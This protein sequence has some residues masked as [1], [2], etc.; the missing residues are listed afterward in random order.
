MRW[1]LHPWFRISVV[2]NL[3]ALC[4]TTV[5]EVS[6]RDRVYHALGGAQR[7]FRARKRVLSPSNQ[8]TVVDF[9]ASAQR[10][11]FVEKTTRVDRITG[12][13]LQISEVLA[14]KFVE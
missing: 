5:F 10:R 1:E 2:L 3:N 13:R 12:C 7:L 6:M 8:S 14:P 11:D 9:E 4:G